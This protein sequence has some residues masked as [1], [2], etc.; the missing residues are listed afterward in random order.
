MMISPECYYENELK[1]K[2]PEQILTVIRSLKRKIA[3]LKR[4]LEAPSYI[5]VK[6]PND[7]VELYWTKKYLERAKAA[8]SESG[9]TY[10]PTKAEI[11]EKEFNENIENIRNIEFSIGG[12]SGYR[13][14]RAYTVLKD[15]IR[16][17]EDY[18]GFTFEIGKE[19]FMEHFQDI[20]I[21]EWDS[22]Y[23]LRKY[24]IAVLDGI[25][26]YLQIEYSNSKKPV[27]I[28]GDN[29]YPYNFKKLLWL[30]GIDSSIIEDDDE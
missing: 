25:Q 2:T 27:Q 28:Y 14:K 4:T 19:E 30:F 7:D 1:G 18:D 9:G 15:R 16:C 22:E 3:K 29:A 6:A 8:L 5:C 23:S 13:P 20:D 17:E 12:F 26:W 11:K 21:G 24:D 10:T